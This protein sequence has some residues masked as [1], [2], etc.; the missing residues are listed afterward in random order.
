[1]KKWILSALFFFSCNVVQAGGISGMIS[2]QI[3]NQISRNVSDAIAKR[4]SDRLLIPQLKIKNESGE[5]IDFHISAEQDLSAAIHDDGSIRVWDLDYGVQRPLQQ[6]DD[7]FRKVVAL[8]NRKLIIAGGEDGMLVVFDVL[9]GKAVLEIDSRMDDI[10]GVFVSSNEKFVMVCDEDGAVA[11]Y[12]S[13]K[14]FPLW[15]LQTSY[16][17]EIKAIAMEGSATTLLIAGEDGF[18]DRW[19]LKA[20]RKLQA[21]ASRGDDILVLKINQE[22]GSLWLLDSDA[23]LQQLTSSGEIKGVIELNESIRAFSFNRMSD[24]LLIVNDKQQIKLYDLK[25]QAFK[26]S[27]D[28]SKKLAPIGFINREKHII[29]IDERGIFRVYDVSLKKEIIQMISTD[30]GWTVVDVV[31]RFDSSEKAMA[32]VSWEVDEDDIGIDRF[33]NRYYEPGLLASTLYDQQFIN[34]AMQAIP[35]GIKLPPEV[36]LSVPD[37]NKSAGDNLIVTAVVQ[38]LGGG[39]KNISLFHNGK[40]VPDDS[41]IDQAQQVDQKLLKKTLRFNVIAMPGKNTFRVVAENN[42]GVEGQS[43]DVLLNADGVLP[44]KPNLHVVTIGINKYMDKRLNL[45]YSVADADS[46]ASL[47]DRVDL[48]KY[49]K[50]IHHKLRDEQASKSNILA[51]LNGLKQYNQQDMVLM[52]VAGHG[53]AVDGEW[54]FLPHE[55]GMQENL[56]YYAKVG[57]SAN[58]VKDILADIKLQR[59]IVMVDACYSGAGL[60]AFRKLVDTQRRFSRSLSKKLGVVIVAATRKDQEAIELADLGHGLF[61]YVVTE[62][63]KG[64]ADKKPRDSLVSA[65]EVAVYSVDTIPGYSRKYIGAAQQPTY[66]T[67]G[68]DFQLLKAR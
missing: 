40:R 46:I 17:D 16:G 3:S 29:A 19:D 26:W 1:M 30:K 43:E 55:T 22:D 63:L 64:E 45:D 18:V 8:S 33:A 5:V 21:F 35:A 54:F 68:G 7:D 44:G 11:V 48:L 56:N 59:F 34:K 15:R 31:G 37:E 41:I 24:S 50:I 12:D 61:T 53:I 58:E 65:H 6:N 62:G 27:L 13:E 9:T 28:V 52:F 39:V 2:Q 42:M 36:N 23:V 20:G 14:F 51:L 57:I 47:F 10:N 38:G 32:N 66:F 49:E 25:K 4:L 67:M 60:Q